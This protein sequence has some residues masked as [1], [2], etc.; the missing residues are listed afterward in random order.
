MGALTQ[1]EPGAI[2]V[3][4]AVSVLL[5]AA[6]HD[7]AFVQAK[8]EEAKQRDP[9]GIKALLK[10]AGLEALGDVSAAAPSGGHRFPLVIGQPVTDRGIPFG[11]LTAGSRAINL[12]LIPDFLRDA[13]GKPVEL[14]GNQAIAAVTALNGG[15]KYGNG[16]ENA[17]TQAVARGEF[18]DGTLILARRS[19]LLKLAGERGT[20]PALKSMNEI[21][22]I[23]SFHTSWC[24]SSTEDSDGS[25][26]V[27]RVSLEDGDGD[28]SIKDCD[29][30]RVVVLRGANCG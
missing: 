27:P 10:A 11:L 14:N 16:Y 18:K 6:K 25:S 17:I 21:I 2:F 24:V 3:E 30:S 13:S 8:L 29:R 15:V 9:D 5:H 1:W 26:L 7:P 23:G 19:D 22:S 20:N 28:W 4:R 12:N